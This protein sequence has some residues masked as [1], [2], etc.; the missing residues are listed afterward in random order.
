MRASASSKPAVYAALAALCLLGAIA[1][2]RPELAIVSVP[3]W[4]TLALGLGGTDAPEVEIEVTPPVERTLEGDE[5]EVAVDVRW[6]RA[7][8]HAEVLLVLPPGLRA[9]DETPNPVGLAPVEGEQQLRFRVRCERWGG[10][11]LG[12]VFVRTRDR[13]GTST[14]EQ[15]FPAQFPLKVYPH[16]EHL[17]STLKPREV[18]VF[19]GNEVSRQRGEGIEFA[20]LR[21]FAYGDRVRRINWRAS[22]RRRELWVN[23]RHPERN[24]DVVLFLDTFADARRTDASTI[25]QAVAAAATLTTRYL[26]QRDRVGLVAFGG[27]LRWFLPG[28]G[29]V[30]RY[31]IVDALID[32]EIIENYAWKDLRIIPVGTLPP[33]AL[34]IA[35]SPL[36]DPRAI[37][38]LLNLRARGFDL[39]VVEISPEP[40]ASPGKSEA[41]ELAYRLWQGTREAMRARFHVAGV[42]VVEWRSGRAADG[43]APGG[44]GIQTLRETR[45]RLT[46]LGAAA[47]V[48]LPLAAYPLTLGERAPGW[49][50]GIAAA[51]AGAA[52]V[53][54]FVG[55]AEGIGAGLV[56]LVGAYAIA[57]D[58]LGSELD[59]RSFAWAAGLYLFAELLF[60]ALELRAPSSPVGA[61]VLRRLAAVGG[62]A[63][64]TF[65]AGAGLLAFTTIG[66]TGGITPMAV[67]VTAVVAAIG[68]LL[69]LPRR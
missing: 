55:L 54:A 56:A 47:A 49:V 37:E 36:L 50:F 21:P 6:R 65:V 20:D 12:D 19:A 22:A 30:Q 41:D 67:G 34:I 33:Q 31:R 1:L 13:F 66:Q 23:D 28:S 8:A 39:A 32:T 24:T 51:G 43:K 11:V 2:R 17:I 35:L 60:L 64:A 29:L 69:L 44:R 62:I 58:E 9:R 27:T 42:A 26:A 7:P 48:S 15:R 18:Q 46:V 63:M 53:A 3:L 61:L 16:E 59:E 38:S 40:F 25:D 14:Y 5:V 45:A 52:L 57:A 4:L 68:L 10:Y